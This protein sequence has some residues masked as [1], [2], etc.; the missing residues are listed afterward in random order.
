MNLYAIDEKTMIE[1]FFKSII[2]LY[3]SN[4]IVYYQNYPLLNAFL[5]QRGEVCFKKNTKFDL[6]AMI[7]GEENIVI[8]KK[9]YHNKNYKVNKKIC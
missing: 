1:I 8:S 5:I 6:L 9:F 3:K 2:F 4:D 7:G